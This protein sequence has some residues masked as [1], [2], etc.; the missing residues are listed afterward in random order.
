MMHKICLFNY[1]QLADLQK[2]LLTTD[3]NKKIFHLIKYSLTTFIF[4]PFFSICTCIML[5]FRRRVDHALHL[6][7]MFHYH[8]P[9]RMVLWANILFC[10]TINRQCLWSSRIF[11]TISD[12]CSF[13]FQSMIC[14]QWY[15]DR[16]PFHEH[17]IV[18]STPTRPQERCWFHSTCIL[19]RHA[20]RYDSPEVLQ[21]QTTIHV[22]QI[23]SALI[24][25][26]QSSLKS[27]Y[28][29]RQ[30]AD[31]AAPSTDGGVSCC[32]EP[33]LCIPLLIWP[34]YFKSKIV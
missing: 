9:V 27:V 30:S 5:K 15:I 28:C 17:L 29:S 7:S 3:L 24:R 14:P 21:T 12:Y 31:A 23:E 6:I 20:S 2:T 10:G 32:N 26:H 19:L 33:R 13:V 4:F 1:G 25:A 18:R 11:L 8:C 34:L 16:R 22:Q